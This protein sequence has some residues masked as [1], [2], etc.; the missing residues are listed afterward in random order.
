MAVYGL[1]LDKQGQFLLSRGHLQEAKECFS[2]AVDVSM[3]L[4]GET[5]EQTLVVQN[6]L[7]TVLRWG[8]LGIDHLFLAG[9]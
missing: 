7:A 4:Q 3:Q 8:I 1:A 6:S 9:V 5:H 2:A